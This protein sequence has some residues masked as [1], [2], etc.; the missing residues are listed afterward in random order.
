MSI[1][2][3]TVTEHELPAWVDVLGTAFLSR[4]DG[5]A[6]AEDVRTFWDLSRAW[7]AFD[8]SAMVGT[9][10]SWA[11][12]LTIPGNIQLPASAVAA[13]AVRAT[14]RRNG[15]LRQIMAAEH[16]AAVERGEALALLYSAE[17]PI[18]GR[19][20]YGP[21][22]QMATW[23]IESGRT[24]VRQSGAGSVEIVRP[25]PAV[26]DDMIAVHAAARLLQVGD[27]ARRDDM[28]DRNLGLRP[29]LW[30]EGW[31]GFVALH[32]DDAGA[33]DGFV[34]YH[35]E[36]KWERMQPEGILTVD[37]F[38]SLGDDAY[39]Q[40]WAFLINTDMVATIKAPQR[41][42]A[43]R[44][45]WLLTNARAASVTELNDSMWVKLLDLPR[46]LAARTYERVA[47]LVIETVE[48]VGTERETRTRVAL[49]AGPDGA[50]CVPTKRSPD[51]TIHA[52]A[53]GAAYLGG[54]SLIHAS[55]AEGADEGRPGV[56]AAAD[57][58]FRTATPP[59]CSIFF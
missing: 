30:D 53:L 24:E 1:V 22:C 12:D 33:V 7:G 43:E 6:I 35:T 5:A 4:V 54:T 49:D 51:L 50:T 20:G 56:L 45:P 36:S 37:D 32:R 55:L 27:I 3:R 58:L 44:F 21:G 48:D 2:V 19:F 57:A 46:A 41:R 47:S 59:W 8:G 18:Y 10:R 16:A 26:R 15:I 17:Y 28:W 11:T 25:T 39:D 13:V 52:G 42:V 14:H 31:K 38:C 23:T 40:L 29:S 9:T 34:R